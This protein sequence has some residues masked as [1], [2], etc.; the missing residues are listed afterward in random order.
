MAGKKFPG[1]RAD[2]RLAQTRRELAW[3]VLNASEFRR[4]ES[5]RWLRRRPWWLWDRVYHALCV[6]PP[7]P[8]VLIK[9]VTCFGI[10]GA[11]WLQL[12]AELGSPSRLVLAEVL[13][14]PEPAWRGPPWGSAWG[15]KWRIAI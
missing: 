9:L 11:Q 1:G 13:A 15:T 8:A 2:Q 12:C 7:D 3:S 5:T 10:D 6:A 14:R 4:W